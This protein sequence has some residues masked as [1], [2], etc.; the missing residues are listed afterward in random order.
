MG[1]RLAKRQVAPQ[2]GKT[3]FRKCIAQRNQ[4]LCLAIGASAV[5]KDQRAAARLF[6]PMDESPDL[7][8]S[9]AVRY[10]LHD[11]PG[12]CFGD[13]Q[14]KKEYRERCGGEIG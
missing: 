3:S 4:Q 7:R 8:L 11:N 1:A 2:H 12:M 9:R 10:R 5:S 6:R 14:S 13:R